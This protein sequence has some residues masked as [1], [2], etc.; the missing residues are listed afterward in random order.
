MNKQFKRSRAH[1][2]HRQNRRCY[3]CGKLMWLRR[4]RRFAEET[5]LPPNEVC[6]YKC[7]GEH[8]KPRSQGG[9]CSRTN[10]AAACRFCN[11]ARHSLRDPPPPKL[12][13]EIV[14]HLSARGEWHRATALVAANALLQA[15]REPLPSDRP[16]S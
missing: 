3:Y 16:R 11:Q 13:R 15:R 9:T 6:L 8:F 4:P 14:R 12:Y 2:F 1:A 5:G 10:I 7:T